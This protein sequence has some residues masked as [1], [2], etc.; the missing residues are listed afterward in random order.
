M[1]LAKALADKGVLRLDGGFGTLLQARGLQPGESPDD[2][3]VDHPDDVSAI[4]AEYYAAGSDIVYANTF[5]SN[6]IKY[7]HSPCGE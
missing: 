2:W 4:H 3:N 6:P 1:D 5:G 7:D